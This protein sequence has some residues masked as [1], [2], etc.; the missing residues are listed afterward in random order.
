MS[1]FDQKFISATGLTFDDVLLVPNYTDAKREN[2]DIS[3]Q[4][5]KNIKLKIPLL[6]SPMDTVTSAKMAAA[7]GSLGGI[8]FI[9]RNLT[10]EAQVE[11]VKKAKSSTSLVGA[12]VGIGKDLEERSQAIVA[13][14]VDVLLVDSAHGYSQWVIE[15]TKFLKNSFKSLEIISGNVATT[16]GA[17][18]L[19]EAGADAIRVGMGPGSICTTR[20]IAGIG[21]PQL[22]SILDTAAVAQKYGIP[23]IADG[24]IRTYGDIVK[25]IAAGASSVMIGS[26]LAGTDESPGIFINRRGRKYKL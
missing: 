24:G 26:L 10:I 4:L 14:G 18:A 15:A 13:T 11:E 8:G 23:V 21:I 19:I 5:T 17:Q 20:I 6:S 22:T 2:I 16:A 3:T 25:A 9:H 7:L 1:E 12:A